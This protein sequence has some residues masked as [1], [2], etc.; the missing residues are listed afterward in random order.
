MS[1]TIT[2]IYNYQFPNLQLPHS[3]IDNCIVVK[4]M[5][6]VIHSQ[7]ICWKKPV[8][9]YVKLIVDDY[10]K[11]NPGSAGEGGIIIDHHSD[12]VMAF[13]VIILQR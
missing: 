4:N 2:L 6:L 10:S 11:S 12:L 13:A 1:N 3:W 7:V 9:A 8:S 5:S